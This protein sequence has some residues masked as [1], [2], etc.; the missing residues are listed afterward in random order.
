MYMAEPRNRQKTSG[1][2]IH[3]EDV[4]NRASTAFKTHDI[5]FPGSSQLRTL[6]NGGHQKS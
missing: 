3:W 4:A 5:A 2:S 1:A 6:A